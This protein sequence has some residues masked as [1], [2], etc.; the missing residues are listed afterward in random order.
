MCSIIVEPLDFTQM[1]LVAQRILS[2]FINV[3]TSSEMKL[4][5]S[6]ET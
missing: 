5:I 1:C 2:Y 3:I 4:N 6:Q